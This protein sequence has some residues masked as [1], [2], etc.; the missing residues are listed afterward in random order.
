M[1]LDKIARWMEV[2]FTKS[3]GPGRSRLGREIRSS[4]LD[5]LNLR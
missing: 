1:F 4:I 5:I 2:K 3:K